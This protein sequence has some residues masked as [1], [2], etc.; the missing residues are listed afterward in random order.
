[1]LRLAAFLTFCLATAACAQ[2]LDT[3]E[4]SLTPWKAGLAPT[5]SD[6]SALEVQLTPEHAMEGK[7]AL[8]L[9]LDRNNQPRAIFLLERS[10]DLSQAPFLKFDVF[11]P[12][13]ADG[14]AIAL[15][16]GNSWEWF[17]SEVQ[18]VKTGQ[19]TVAFDLTSDRFKAARSSWNIGTKVEGLNATQR[20][21]L[22][23][24]PKAGGSVYL[25]NLR[26]DQTGEMATATATAVQAVQTSPSAVAPEAPRTLAA[27]EPQ[28][29]SI[30]KLGTAQA[31][32]LTPLEL[33]I[34]T[35]GVYSNPY[36]PEQADLWVTFT[37]ASGKVLKIP[38]F[39]SLDIDPNTLQPGG[40][41]HWKV[42]FT[43]PEA[44]NW[45]AQA[46]L[47][48]GNIQSAPVQLTAAENPAAKGLVQ[49]NKT[50]PLYFQYSNGDFYLPTGLNVAWAGGTGQRTLDEYQRW[51]SRLSE[52]GGNIARVWM[53][54]WNLGIEWKDTGLGNYQNRQLQAYLLDQVFKLAE[55]KGIQL[56]LALLNH[57]AFSANINP[58]WDDNPFNVKN[59]G[60]LKSPEEFA[61]N[62]EAR[63][64]FKQ[65]LRYIVARWGYSPNL[66]A[67]EWW[68][69][70]N[71]TPIDDTL[72]GP[73]IQ[74]M[75][76]YL[77]TLDPYNHLVSS[78]YG[79][80]SVGNTWTLPELDFVQEHDYSQRDVGR[81]LP[82][83]FRQLSE[84]TPGK[85]VMLSELG[86]SSAGT[87]DLPLSRD[88]IQFH[89]GLWAAPFSGFASTG[90]YWWWD[91]FIDPRNLWTHYK[92]VSDFFKGENL[93]VMAPSKVKT[94][95]F[96][97]ALALG[98]QNDSRALV[99]VRN[100]IYDPGEAMKVYAE[101]LR[102][103]T[104]KEGWVFSPEPVKD[105][106][107]TVSGL[108]DGNYQV[109]F[110]DPQAN[111]WLQTTSANSTGGVLTVKVSALVKDLAFKV[112]PQ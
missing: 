109:Q 8:E 68:N 77:K 6:S 99:W 105:L 1:M 25:D 96:F 15:S 44:G 102:T 76:A 67:W 62:A 45:T 16:T 107:V 18:P 37:S 11:N 40:T 5:Y 101:A 112:I 32:V 20:I 57:G 81:F 14:V 78:S 100:N 59:G 55:A 71:W 10:L 103:G 84:N 110:Y 36:D 21:A 29:A 4:G 86:Y 49:I 94:S 64:F 69:E 22:L 38:A 35:D 73:W 24:F 23:V 48:Q 63:K 54:S 108:K 28:P 53:P 95:D 39:Y 75:T 42:R 34:E 58:E 66:F 12:D 61:T 82:P 90:M 47:R 56:E 17:E 9:K 106:D 3:F 89:N 19:Q 70:V 13:V 7:Q 93:A 80:A 33:P 26:L 91:N 60:M 87:D 52:N 97:G 51:F 92:G 85:P 30:L 88:E 50:N 31:K 65:R 2:S 72:L 27:G 104:Y 46:G 79:S 41:G 74:E 83:S 111:Q 43:P 98:L